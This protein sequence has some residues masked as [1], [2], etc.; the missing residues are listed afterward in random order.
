[1]SRAAWCSLVAGALVFSAC[2]QVAPAGPTAPVPSPSA[3]AAVEE[4]SQ[5][6]D[7]ASP[8]PSASAARPVSPHAARA[9]ALARAVLDAFS[10]VDP[11]PVTREFAQQPWVQHV[12][13]RRRSVSLETPWPEPMFRLREAPVR[14]LHGGAVDVEPSASEPCQTPI[15]TDEDARVRWGSYRLDRGVAEDTLRV[16]KGKIPVALPRGAFHGGCVI[17]QRRLWIAWS[18]P[19]SPPEL[20]TVTLRDGRV[21]PLRD[22]ARPSLGGLA[23]ITSD[24][25]ALPVGEPPGRSAEVLRVRQKQPHPGHES[26]LAPLVWITSGLAHAAGPRRADGSAL[27]AYR[28][29][30]RALVEAGAEVIVSA[31]GTRA[32]RAE[33]ERQA[34]AGLARGE[35]RRVW[36][37]RPA[38]ELESSESSSQLALSTTLDPATALAE[39]L[40][41]F[42]E[43]AL[44]PSERAG[45]Q[46]HG[47]AQ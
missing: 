11:R 15:V 19:A 31:S 37:V 28:P 30:V 16:D 22:E 3:S 45:E 21:R 44:G 40:V 34:V 39:L 36:A 8:A 35:G 42:D 17:D 7:V 46:P 12:S 47:A 4:V 9:N 23:E 29:V 5:L 10:N 1:M 13:D 26:A 6:D 18:T 32:L 38:S 25:A 43:R 14:L 27:A 33:V 24:V 20:F 41:A 2:Q